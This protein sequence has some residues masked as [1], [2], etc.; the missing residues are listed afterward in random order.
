MYFGP[1][2]RSYN[3]PQKRS[4]IVCAARSKYALISLTRSYSSSTLDLGATGGRASLLASFASLL[5][6]WFEGATG[7]LASLGGNLALK[8]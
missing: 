1:N 4:M 7:S 2:V 6:A 8:T 5:T 3:P